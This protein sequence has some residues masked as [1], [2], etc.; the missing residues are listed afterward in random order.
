MGTRKRFEG[1]GA[2]IFCTLP[3]V[4]IIL[5]ACDL[6]GKGE[7]LGKE[8]VW[9]CKAAFARYQELLRNGKNPVIIV[10]AGMASPRRWPWQTK[11][12]AEMMCDYL[13]EKGIS[14]SNIIVGDP[15]WSSWGEMNAGLRLMRERGLYSQIEGKGSYLKVVDRGRIVIESEEHVRI[16]YAPEIVSGWYHRF[17]LWLIWRMVTEKLRGPRTRA[18]RDE[19]KWTFIPA[20][21]RMTNF[22]LEFLKIPKLFVLHNPLASWLFFLFRRFAH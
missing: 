22:L 17:R 14:K 21:G 7:R 5:F 20:K 13:A 6:A 9:R 12:L 10:T 16:T 15:S 4:P 11:T 3:V 18:L 19:W 1:E 2:L 8:S